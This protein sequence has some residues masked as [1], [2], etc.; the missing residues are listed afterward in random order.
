MIILYWLLILLRVLKT[1]KTKKEND[2]PRA[3]NHGNNLVE[4][5]HYTLEAENVIKELN[6]G[7]AL[8][9]CEIVFEE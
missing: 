6:S 5:C 7:F 8:S 3:I 4:T 1:S 9:T 2:N